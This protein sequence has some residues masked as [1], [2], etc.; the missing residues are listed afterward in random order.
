M[1]SPLCCS[2]AK[3]CAKYL[4]AIFLG[5]CSLWL[6]WDLCLKFFSGSTTILREQEQNNYL[7]LPRFLLCNKQRYNKD[8]L[9]AMEL[10][11]DFFD[12]LNPDKSRFSNEDSFPDLNYTWQRATWP[13]TDFEIDWKRYEGMEVHIINSFFFI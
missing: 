1:L 13:M 11:D 4:L 8:E 6:V 10:P 7:P 5:L 3:T 9:A 12:N 2:K